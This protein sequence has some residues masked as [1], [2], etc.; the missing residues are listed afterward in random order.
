MMRRSPIILVLLCTSAAGSTGVANDVELGLRCAELNHASFE[1]G[2]RVR[3]TG[4]YRELIDDQLH[5][6]DCDLTFTLEKAHQQ[7]L[8]DFTPKKDNLTL[9]GRIE[10]SIDGI[11]VRV[12]RLARAPGDLELFTH[13]LDG[14]LEAMPRPAPPRFIDLG[15]RIAEARSAGG[16]ERLLT[17]SRKAFTAAVE[18]L[19]ADADALTETLAVVDRIYT[20]SQDSALCRD[21]VQKIASSHGGDPALVSRLERWGCREYRG[22]WVTREEHRELEGFVLHDGEWMSPRE[23]HYTEALRIFSSKNRDAVAL[24]R[25][26]TEREYRSLAEKRSVVVGMNRQEVCLALGFPE[27]VYRKAHEGDEFDQWVYGESRYYYFFDGVLVFQ[28]RETGRRKRPA[29]KSR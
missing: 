29:K 4:K 14:M 18:T 7:A 20:L 5:L 24:L 16:D 9:E 3:V 8:L 2:E 25:N 26:R 19:S 23:R 10:R 22:R 11:A 1:L 6:F 28:P 13:E 12:D 27:F 21:L 17:L 15:R